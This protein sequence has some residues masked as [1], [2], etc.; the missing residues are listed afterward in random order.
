[1]TVNAIE[2]GDDKITTVIA[3]DLEITG[4]IKFKSSLMLKCL[5]DGEILSEGLL[6]IGPTAKVKATITTQNLISHGEITGDVTASEQVILKD[7]S[8]HVG[9]ITTRNILIENGS[10]FNG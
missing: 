9:N 6:I 1:M 8:V 3:E 7:T 5:F 2:Y 4:T 10:I